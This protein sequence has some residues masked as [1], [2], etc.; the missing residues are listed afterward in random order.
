MGVQTDSAILQE[1]YQKIMAKFIYQGREPEAKERL[2]HLFCNQMTFVSALAPEP[3]DCNTWTEECIQKEDWDG[4]CRIINQRV[5]SAMMPVIYGGYNYEKNIHCVLECLLCGNVQVVERILPLDLA[6]VKNCLNPFFPAAAHV[7]IGLWYKDE[8][9][10]EWAV[11]DAERFL[12]GKKPNLLEKAMVSF[13]LDLVSGN[14]EKGSEDLLAVCKGYPKD[15]R[16]VLGIRPFCTYAH[17]LYCLAQLLLPKSTFQTL[18]MPEY[19]NFLPDFALWRQ[20]NHDLDLSL[21]FRYPEGMELFNDIYSAP[22]A[23]LVLMPPAPDD[24]KQEWFAHGVKWV[25]NYVDEL[26]DMGIGQE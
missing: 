1:K 2:R 22:P 11:P 7:L 24:K 14:M 13:L 8:A 20:E 9:V 6:L 15:K 26:W 17:G 10:L 21:W 3:E 16:P 18:K 19:K 23:K 25:N 5:K 12:E 4:L